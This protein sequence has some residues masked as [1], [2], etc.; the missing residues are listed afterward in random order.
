MRTLHTNLVVGRDHLHF[1]LRQ[2]DFEFG[3]MCVYCDIINVK[4]TMKTTN[5]RDKLDYQS[6]CQF[7]ICFPIN[8]ILLHLDIHSHTYASPPSVPNLT[9]GTYSSYTILNHI[10]PPQLVFILLMEVEYKIEVI[11]YSKI[12]RI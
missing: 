4:T 9:V 12:I 8:N 6:P 3:I 2:L 10:V 7:V 11:F 1:L 5:S